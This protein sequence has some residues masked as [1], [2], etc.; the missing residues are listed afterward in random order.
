MGAR[1]AHPSETR[2]RRVPRF[3]IRRLTVYKSLR[4]DNEEARTKGKEW[5]IKI[6]ESFEPRL[7]PPSLLLEKFRATR[8]DIVITNGRVFS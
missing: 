7:Q 2:F 4:R 5:D 3:S 6:S 8:D 1:A